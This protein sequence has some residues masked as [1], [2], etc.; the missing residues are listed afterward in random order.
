MRAVRLRERAEQRGNQI[1]LAQQDHIIP[2]LAT[3]I[4]SLEDTSMDGPLSVDDVLQQLRT[5]LAEA[6]SALE[7]VGAAGFVLAAK[8]LQRTISE[9]KARICALEGTQ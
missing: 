5:D 7:E 2:Y 3:R 4:K 6:E 8:H 1:V 9:L